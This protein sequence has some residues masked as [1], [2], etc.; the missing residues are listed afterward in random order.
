MTFEAMSKLEGGLSMIDNIAH[1]FDYSRIDTKRYTD[2]A[3]V[4][5]ESSANRSPAL[6]PNDMKSELERLETFKNW[7]NGEAIS[8]SELAKAGFYYSSRGDRVQCVFCK[9]FLRNWKAGDDA[10][11]EHRRHFP[12]CL[13][14]QGQD[15]GN[16]KI[17]IEVREKAASPWWSKSVKTALNSD[18]RK[19]N[20][21]DNI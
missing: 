11:T 17:K 4:R 21:I 15:V 2:D 7:P 6:D 10:M 3:G 9:N 18:T 13:F 20:K 8:P 19:G 1:F 14:V 12:R 5:K 16:I